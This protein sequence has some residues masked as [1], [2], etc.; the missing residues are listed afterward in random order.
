[1]RNAPLLL[2]CVMVVSML[3]ACSFTTANYSDL[4]MASEIDADN[5]PLTITDTFSADSPVIYVTGSMNNAPEGTMI[6]AEWIYA[7]ENPPTFI[8][9]AELEVNEI[10]SSFHFSMTRP[11]NGW[12]AGEYEVNLYI[13]DELAETLS[14]TVE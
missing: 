6:A 3:A 9:V 8:D 2:L 1:M 7:E 12:P 11:D 10:S 4:H 14:F 13:D 5:N